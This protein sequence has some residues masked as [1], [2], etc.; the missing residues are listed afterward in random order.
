[1]HGK[2]QTLVAETA[3]IKEIYEKDINSVDDVYETIINKPI[4][5]STVGGETHEAHEI[6]YTWK[7]LSQIAKVISNNYGQEAGKINN[8]TAEVKVSINGKA[9]TL[10][11]GDWT[12]VN[13]KQ[14]RILGFNHDELAT[15]RENEDGTTEA[16]APQYGAGTLN[17][18]AGISFEYA[19]CIGTDKMNTTDINTGGWKASTLRVTLNS[20]IYD[21]LE[22]KQY[23]KEV[24]KQYIEIYNNPDSVT[25]SQ[26]KVWLLS[27]SEIWNN[28]YT[29][30]AYGQAIAKEGEQYKYYSNIDSIYSNSNSIIMKNNNGY[31]SPWWLRSPHYARNTSFCN[32][33]LNGYCTNNYA[34]YV[35]GISAGFSI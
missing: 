21:S 12:T 6:P 26:D 19:E 28:G 35:T 30:G 20:T 16:I 3:R 9:D 18:Y 2:E 14:V 29:S 23:I 34:R 8:N 5:A 22:N 17:T 32:V 13:G 10:G 11:I 4:S 31:A 27:C 15:E 24:N 33:H 25:T 1:M 7:E